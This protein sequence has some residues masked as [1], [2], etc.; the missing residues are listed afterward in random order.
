MCPIA[1]NTSKRISKLFKYPSQIF[2][3]QFILSKKIIYFMRFIL[4]FNI[5]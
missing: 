2:K 1:K 5:F 4:Y 3:R